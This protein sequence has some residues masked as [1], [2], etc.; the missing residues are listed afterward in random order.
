MSW[1]K[2]MFSVDWVVGEEG[3]GQQ[4]QNIGS[5]IWIPLGT[6]RLMEASRT[7]QKMVKKIDKTKGKPEI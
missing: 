2:A 6:S 5:C 3:K 1:L 4:Q 7:I